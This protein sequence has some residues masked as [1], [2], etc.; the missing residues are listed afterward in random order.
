[1]LLPFQSLLGAVLGHSPVL[2]KED[3]EQDWDTG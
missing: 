1:M 2:S 3:D